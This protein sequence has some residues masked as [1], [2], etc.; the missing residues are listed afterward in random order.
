MPISI[1]IFLIIF[2][3]TLVAGEDHHHHEEFTD[4]E[5]HV[6]GHA[7]AYISNEDDIVN[8]KLVLPSIDVFGFEHNPK[9]EEQINKVHSQLKVL[10]NSHNLFVIDSSCEQLGANI[11]S[12]VI[13]DHDEEHAHE[14][15]H[16]HHDDHG[17]D[18]YHEEDETHSNVSAA[19]ELNCSAI[20]FEKI[21]FKIFDTFPSVE[22]LVVQY[23]SE[24]T[25][26][27]TT[28]S[29]KDSIFYLQQ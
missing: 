19:Y 7:E 22:R 21:H 18:D 11:E 15:E 9:N 12:G 13:S 16:H 29:P 5:A 28:L 1:L 6:H 4:H 25:Q 17:H 23:V 20:K 14:N 26:T 24:S 8:V 10:D 2:S 27:S 3:T